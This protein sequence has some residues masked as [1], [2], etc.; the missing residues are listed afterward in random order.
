M[1]VVMRSPRPSAM[2]CQVR[3][4]VKVEAVTLCLRTLGALLGLWVPLEFAL[5]A[6]QALRV[7]TSRQKLN[8]A[9]SEA[10]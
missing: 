10:L 6:V 9:S 7:R 2:A 1:S 8:S 5:R 4:Y 3:E